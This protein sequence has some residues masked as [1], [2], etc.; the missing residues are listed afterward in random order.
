MALRNIHGFLNP[1]QPTGN[2]FLDPVREGLSR[3]H[4]PQVVF[5]HKPSSIVHLLTVASYSAFDL[6]LTLPRVIH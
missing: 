5:R 3:V 6:S 4:V 2:D 1:V